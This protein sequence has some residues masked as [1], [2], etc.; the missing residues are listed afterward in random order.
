MLAEK[1]AGLGGPWSDHLEGQ[2]AEE[3][4]LSSSVSTVPVIPLASVR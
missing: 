1:G 2:V 4:S 3:R